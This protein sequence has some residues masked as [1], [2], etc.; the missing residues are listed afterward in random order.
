MRYRHLSGFTLIEVLVVISIISVLTSLVLA[1]IWIARLRCLEALA[2]TE[3]SGMKLALE[4]YVQDEAV[5]PGEADPPEG[6]VPEEQNQ[7]PELYEAIC[8]ARAPSGRGG[9]SSPYVNL[10][11]ERLAVWD[12]GLGAYRQATRGEI[13]DP[14]TPK[15]LLDPFQNPYVYRLNRG[16]PPKPHAMNPAGADLYSLGLNEVDDTV[17]QAE[18][19]DDI[20][21][22]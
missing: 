3:V 9:R 16:R 1:G 21:N 14:E 5:Y 10:P 13:R 6:R 17:A 22:W 8:G 11:S 7:F 15:L 19:S 4:G 12:D 18:G 2:K 20:G